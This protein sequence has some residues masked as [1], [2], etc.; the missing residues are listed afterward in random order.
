M[1]FLFLLMAMLMLAMQAAFANEWINH[2]YERPTPERLVTEVRAWSKS[3]RMSDPKTSGVVIAFL[4]QVMAS[5]P[6]RIEGWL[7]ELVD[8]NGPDRQVLLTAAGQSGTKEARAY[9][10]R[11]PEGRRYQGNG[12]DWRALEP[13]NPV[14]LDM[15]WADFL[16]TGE[17][18]PVRRVV[19]ALNYEKYSGAIDRYASSKKTAQDRNDAV[20]EAVFKAALWSLNSNARQHR[21]VRDILEQ[22]IATEEL[23]SSE[24]ACLASLLLALMP[25]KYEIVPQEN[26][27]RSFRRK[28]VD[29]SAPAG[30]SAPQ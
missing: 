14:V 25:E 7:D 23:T 24:Q 20:L 10:M 2:Y 1:R 18:V 3:G 22:M 29:Q 9:L 12:R 13:D 19:K 27:M 30:L 15:L 8:L 28:P 16:A 11:Q 4:A 17:A 26:G 21:R 5:N 6:E